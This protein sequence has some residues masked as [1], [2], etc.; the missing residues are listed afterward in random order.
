MNPP[1][2]GVPVRLVGGH[3]PSVIHAIKQTP[4]GPEIAVKYPDGTISD[5]APACYYDEA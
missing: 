5:F 2:I 4:N 3:A 1:E